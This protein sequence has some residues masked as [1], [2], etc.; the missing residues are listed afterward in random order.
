MNCR[1]CDQRKQKWRV[2][3]VGLTRRPFKAVFAGFKSRT[4]HHMALSSIGQENGFSA[5][6]AGFNS[7]KRH[8]T[9]DLFDSGRR[10]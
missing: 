5:R 1:V 2:G 7:L 4:R 6:E 8:Q 10:P 9:E 3:E